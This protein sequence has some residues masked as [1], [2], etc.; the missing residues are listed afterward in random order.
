MVQTGDADHHLLVAPLGE[1]LSAHRRVLAGDD[2]EATRGLGRR[3]G[4]DRGVDHGE[5]DARADVR[6]QSAAIGERRVDAHRRRDRARRHGAGHR[7][8]EDLQAHP[9]VA[10]IGEAETVVDPRRLGEI[11]DLRQAHA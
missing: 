6:E 5:Q 8:L 10:A 4:P 1:D 7:S 9:L 11:L 2:A 3:V